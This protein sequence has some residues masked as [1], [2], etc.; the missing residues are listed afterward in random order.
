MKKALRAV[1][2]CGLAIL[3]VLGIYYFAVPKTL[4]FRGTVTKIEAAEQT[5][6]FYIETE[7]IGTSYVVIAD[8]KTKISPCHKD[9]P[10]IDIEDIKVGDV[11]EG[12]YRRLSKEHTAKFITVW[13]QNP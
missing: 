7:S 3:L 8:H 10:K 4:D 5:T 12:D 2:L 9:D 11:I 1:V 13:V 6:T